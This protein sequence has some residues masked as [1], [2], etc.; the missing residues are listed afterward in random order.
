ML[1]KDI[2]I[3]KLDLHIAIRKIKK[4]EENL[5]QSLKR[6]KNIATQ[7]NDNIYIE[8]KIEET[9]Q[10]KSS[11]K[12][13]AIF[14]ELLEKNHALQDEVTKLRREQEIHLVKMCEIMEQK[15]KANEEKRLLSEKI[16]EKN[17]EI[18]GLSI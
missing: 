5:S 17:N 11:D 4:H 8:E 16:E 15:D 1:D 10:D 9:C 18:H 6:R 2:E 13:D 3:E 12:V 7:V 14:R